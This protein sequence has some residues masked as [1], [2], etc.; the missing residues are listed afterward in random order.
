MQ[1]YFSKKR[2][3]ESQ[4]QRAQSQK[5]LEIFSLHS[6]PSSQHEISSPKFK[7]KPASIIIP[8]EEEHSVSSVEKLLAQESVDKAKEKSE[9]KRKYSLAQE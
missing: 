3:P 1:H 7:P 9:E 4:P 8:K 5:S 6:P 2:S